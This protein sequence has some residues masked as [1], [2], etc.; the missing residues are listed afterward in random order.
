LL[1]SPERIVLDPNAQRLTTG[2]DAVRAQVDLFGSSQLR[3]TISDQ[4]DPP[5]VNWRSRTSGGK[6]IQYPNQW[7]VTAEPAERQLSTRFLAAIQVTGDVEGSVLGDPV[8]E[9]ENVIRTS[10]WRITAAL[11]PTRDASLLIERIDGKAALAIDYD[12]F[13][14][15]GTKY[16]SSVSETVLVEDANQLVRRCHDELPQAARHLGKDL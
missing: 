15:A 12:E 11:A 16:E 13:S 1:H 4:F 3:V 7:H 10:N 6:V 2:T 14:V 8:R 5:A 9:A